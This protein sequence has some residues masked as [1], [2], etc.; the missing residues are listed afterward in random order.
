MRVS[1]PAGV[2]KTYLHNLLKKLFWGEGPPDPVALVTDVANDG[3]S[4]ALQVGVGGVDFIYVVVPT[5][6]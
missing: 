6:T 3:M 5:V 1:W 4:R 2:L